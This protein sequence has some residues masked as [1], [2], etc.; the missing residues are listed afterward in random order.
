MTEQFN[1]P[2]NSEK[3]D[4]MI[5]ARLGDYTVYALIG[6]GGM[7]RVYE[8]LD[9]K[10][11]RKAAIKVI[12][13]EHDQNDEMTQRFIREARAAANL[14]HPNII[15]VYQFGE[16]SSGYY[17][18]MKL[19]EGNTLLSILKKLKQQKTYLEPEMIVAIV[20]QISSA[21]DYAHSKNVIHRDI[22]PS[23]IML[24]EDNRAILTD[25]GLTMTVGSETTLGT[26]FGTP[27]Y[28]AP[29]QA[30]ASHQAGAQSISGYGS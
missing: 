3:S 21:L 24:N 4:P 23:N 14:D 13:V 7:A 19:I 29:E 18:A 11:G 15:S 20:A 27:R 1:E 26:A 10:L 6:R 5:G 28:I 2:D 25:F 22:K 12:S 8:G 16:S 17:M 30:I 9:E